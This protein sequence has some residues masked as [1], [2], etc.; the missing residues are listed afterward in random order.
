MTAKGMEGGEAASW[1][2]RV[3]HL[4]WPM[5]LSNMSMTALGVVDTAVMGRLPD[6]AYIGAVAVGATIIGFIYWGLAFLRMGTT[7]LS[8]QAFG[9]GAADEVRATLARALLLALA[10][11]IAIIILKVPIALLA[12][13]VIEASNA[14]IELA[15]VYF[16][17][18]LWAMPASLIN[19][20]VLGWLIGVQRTR[21]ALVV[22]LG[23]NLVNVALAIL[24]VIGL[25]WGVEGAASATLIAEWSGVAMSAAAIW[26]ALRT[27]GGRLDPARIFDRQRLIA[28]A[29]INANVFVRSLLVVATM[30]YFTVVGARFGDATL[31]ANAMLAAV[32]SFLGQ[33]L[34]G[35]SFAAE[36][37]VGSAIG[38]RDRQ[39]L[40]S[41]VRATFFVA[42]ALALAFTL[43]YAILGAAVIGMLTDLPDVRHQ[44]IIYLPWAAVTPIVLVWGFLLDGV[45]NGATHTREM[46]NAMIIS[47]AGYI[48][49]IQLLVPL[50]GNHGLWAAFILFSLLRIVTLGAWYPRIP[51]SIAA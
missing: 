49:G 47:A 15:R 1:R 5:I 19:M 3:W 2:R 33:A 46:R 10:L 9:T 25:G 26:S 48:G 32:N 45:F 6:A 50:W 44:A 38:A 36:A 34:D 18:R 35:F 12:F 37:L 13:G 41:A 42:G 40:R 22:Q 28:V 39:Q 8:A 20:V 14:V 7:G 31:A 21:A 27:V 24:F 16:D 17:I 23:F 43:G 30:A 4:A 29:H 11:G 51:Q